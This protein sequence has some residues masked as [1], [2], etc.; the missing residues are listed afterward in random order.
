[1]EATFTPEPQE[2]P[3][4]E[5][6]A[7]DVPDDAV[8]PEPEAEAPVEP[9]ENPEGDEPPEGDTPEPDPAG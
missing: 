4:S 1:M 5:E 8:P 2:A 9:D 3:P 7:V 6:N